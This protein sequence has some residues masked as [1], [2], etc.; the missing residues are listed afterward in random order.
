MLQFYECWALFKKMKIFFY[1][2]TV[3][4]IVGCVQ[5]KKY[6]VKITD[7][8]PKLSKYL[9]DYPVDGLVCTHQDSLATNYFR[10]S[11]T[12]KE[13]R[14]VLICEIPKYRIAAFNAILNIKD[15]EYFSILLNHL[16]DTSKVTWWA[17]YDN[18]KED[19]VSDLMIQNAAWKWK[20]SQRQKDSLVDAVLN[21]YMYLESAKWM[22]ND[23]RPQEKYYSIIKLAAQNKSNNCGD[24]SYTYS[25][26]KFKKQK[27]IELIKKNFNKFTDNP[28][29]ND[30]CFEAIEV[31]PDTAFF[32]LLTKYLNEVIRKQKHQGAEDLKYYC[33]AV[34][35]YKN[36][37][38]LEILKAL[39]KKE[40][41][42]DNNYLQD[43][44]EFVFYAIHR[45]SSPIY[46]N[47]YNELKPQMSHF[48]LKNPDDPAWYN[49]TTW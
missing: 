9:N 21:N 33:R 49:E 32:P 15:A 30:I 42:P 25:L 44:K 40:T 27:D 16:D 7:I 3:I 10:D 4:T 28:F 8:N 35:E 39:T 22:I 23:I 31:F 6:P 2:L 17:S 20:L 13:L 19:Y 45:Y 41:Y 43:N 12:K 48:V 47:L 26:A 36:Q 29:C 38:S 24:L 46:D 5:G 1:I 37:K 18:G 11:C 34:A 14:D